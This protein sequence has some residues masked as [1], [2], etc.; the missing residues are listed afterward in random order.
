MTDKR[1][2][3][4]QES[5]LKPKLLEQLKKEYEKQHIA[6]ALSDDQLELVSAAGAPNTLRICPYST[7]CANCAWFKGYCLKCMTKN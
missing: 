3:F 1:N 2:D 7:P 6:D 4:S 5:G